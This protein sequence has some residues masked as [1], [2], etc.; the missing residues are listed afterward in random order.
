MDHDK[1]IDK[2]SGVIND[3]GTFSESATIDQLLRWKDLLVGYNYHLA[4]VVSEYFKN[5]SR[6]YYIRKI[7]ISRVKNRLV[8]EGN[9]VTASESQAVEEAAGEYE[10]ELE[11]EATAERLNNLL[12]QSNKV[13]EAMA[14]R[15]SVL[16]TE[17]HD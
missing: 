13:V 10:T 2:I 1:L 14:Q 9:P 16:K 11:Y 3:Y 5:Y 12:R 4:E 15:V 7:K 6:S 17:R 8:K